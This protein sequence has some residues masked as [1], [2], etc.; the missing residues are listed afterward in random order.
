VRAIQGKCKI[1]IDDQTIIG[2]SVYCIL[3]DTRGTMTI[4][5][6]LAGKMWLIENFEKKDLY[7]KLYARERVFSSRISI[8]SSPSHPG[9]GLST[10]LNF[11]L[12]DELK[13]LEK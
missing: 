13:E 8:T 12:K 9:K 6:E 10:R 4:T 3:T 1:S 2:E 11:L 7:L 5:P